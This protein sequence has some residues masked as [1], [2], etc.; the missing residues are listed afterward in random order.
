MGGRQEAVRDAL[1]PPPGVVVEEP[2]V[3]RGPPFPPDRE[4]WPWL[5][6][7]LVL[8]LVGVGVGLWLSLRDNGK[9][10][11]ATT[12]PSTVLATQT[13]PTQPATAT[14]TVP[15]VA[16]LAQAAAVEQLRSFGFKT[17]IR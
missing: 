5:L 13:A 14:V 8:A 9:K 6:L 17:A 16:G 2:P 7:L 1:P 10:H 11:A 4:L 3:R 12:A 15:K